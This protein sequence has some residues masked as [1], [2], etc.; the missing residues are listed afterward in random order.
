MRRFLSELHYTFRAVLV[1]CLAGRFEVTRKN[2]EAKRAR[3]L[4]SP[5]VSDAEMDRRA[6]VL[7]G[8]L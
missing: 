3:R 5:E 7:M 1:C 4:L 8:R 2:V 6:L